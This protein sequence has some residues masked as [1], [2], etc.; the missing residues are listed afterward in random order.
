LPSNLKIESE[1]GT[2]ECKF[3]S[4]I[5]NELSYSRTIVIN[6]GYYSKEKYES[7]RLF[8]EQIAKNESIKVVLKTN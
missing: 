3:L 8:R 2:Y 7:Y 4:N 1:F 6:E 5:K